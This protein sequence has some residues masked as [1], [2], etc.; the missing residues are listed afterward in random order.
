[1]LRGENMSCEQHVKG[2]ILDKIRTTKGY[3]NR[4]D[5]KSKEDI[6]WYAENSYKF[7]D[8]K[9]KML[10][11]KATKTMT[12]ENLGKPDFTIDTPEFYIVIETKGLENGKK[13]SR[14]ENVTSYINPEAK[15][16]DEIYDVNL[17]KQRKCAIDEALYYATFLNTE[18]HVIAIG[19]SGTYDDNSF[20]LTAFF[21]PKGKMLS[22]LRIIEDGGINDTFNTVEG[23]RR[24]VY[25]SLGYEEKLY[26]VIYEDLRI[27]ADKM[28]K[29]LN[30]NGVDE[31]DRLGL[32][33]AIA[34][35]LTNKESDLY[36]KVESGNK[37]EITPDE[38]KNALLSE[39]KPVGLIIKD[40]L[41]TEKRNILKSYFLALLNK[42][43]LVRN[44]KIKEGK[45][46]N[47]D[48]YFEDYRGKTDKIL[49]RLTYSL[50]KYI[51]KVYDVYQSSNIDV[52]GSFYSLF[53][54]YVKADVKKGVVLT[55]KHITELFCDLAEYYLQEKL[56]YRTRVL[57]ICTGSGGFLIAALNRICQNIDNDL[58]LNENKKNEYK[59][60]A[61]KRSLIGI[62][63][64]DSMFVLAYANMRFHHD[65]K[66]LL[67]FGSSLREDN[68]PLDDDDKTFEQIVAGWYT[69]EEDLTLEEKIEVSGPDVGMINPPY[70]EDVFE[71]IDSMLYYLRK[72]GIGIAIVP[73]NTQCTNSEVTEKKNKVLKN[74]TLLASILMPPTL[75]KRV[76]GSGAATS[77]CILVFKAHK[78]HKE[79]IDNGGL[80]YLADWS[81]DGFKFIPKHGRFEEDD[82]WYDS[83]KGYRKLY[84]E[85]IKNN[86]AE[87]DYILSSN[88]HKDIKEEDANKSIKK[89][90]HKFVKTVETEKKDKKGKVIYRKKRI[91]KKNEK[92]EIQYDKRGNPKYIFIEEKDENGNLIPEVDKKE[93]YA[94]E[95]WNIL[96]YV[97]TD[98]S[99]LQTD[100]FIKTMLD[101]NL[102]LYMNDN[103]VDTNDE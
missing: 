93:V 79:F 65:G 14:F 74:N 26:R 2:I 42:P 18:K 71:F 96:D 91:E 69:G 94:N 17:I 84:L 33:S 39:T 50:F 31:N 63:S 97:K 9:L 27:Y 11:D 20:R 60:K 86:H 43:I 37:L 59:E 75:F 82:K 87:K 76:R 53:L 1:M 95:D 77:T 45:E 24:I 66:S 30:T 19:A 51:V 88:Y 47:T 81:N 16:N 99:E 32:V 46:I 35:A 90:I 102:F 13:H 4:Q 56:S 23:Y 85:D 38:V 29:F 7:F 92:G 22:D 61:R 98:Y 64:K 83:E 8:P 57:D 49:S 10:L 54:Q 40:E 5:V 34:L 68:M 36:K 89:P 58:S 6:A 3:P 12:K 73:I 101:Y 100:D 67:Y 55:P 78:P 15:S 80:T 41:P 72:D 25:K 62:E 28:A 48:V 103:G 52:M 70:E 44:V 21:L